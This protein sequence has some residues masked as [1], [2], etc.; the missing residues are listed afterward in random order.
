MPPFWSLVCLALSTVP[1]GGVEV[2][3]RR[4]ATR[5]WSDD[6][7]YS[8]ISSEQAL[9]G[10]AA[11]AKV[12][13]YRRL[14][15]PGQ[16]DDAGRWIVSPVYRWIAVRHSQRRTGDE[17]TSWT[18]SEV[19]PALAPALETFGALEVPDWS[20]DTPSP[21]P[22]DREIPSTRKDGPFV[23]V[24]TTVARPFA[25]SVRVEASF[26]PTVVSDD[27]QQ[28]DQSLESCW[29]DGEPDLSH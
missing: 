13:F 17:A 28:I 19:C 22:R 11:A 23:T 15:V 10:R 1:N 9:D 26:L 21:S 5:L 7:G 3:D 2:Q 20:L 4:H 24:W 12:S 27:V 14:V 8:I 25:A 29:T 18:R 16:S 6:A